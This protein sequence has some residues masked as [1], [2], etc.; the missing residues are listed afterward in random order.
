MIGSGRA[1]KVA[2]ARAPAMPDVA[3][4]ALPERLDEDDRAP[5]DVVPLRP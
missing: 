2:I 1:A 3:L 5:T 4:P